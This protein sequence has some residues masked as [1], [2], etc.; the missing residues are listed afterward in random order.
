[1][2]PDDLLP[3]ANSD[4][5]PL[6]IRLVAHA[7][8]GAATLE[9]AELLCRLATHGYR[10]VARAAGLRLVVL[11]GSDGI[12]RLQKA[13]VTVDEHEDLNSLLTATRDAEL[14]LYGLA[15]LW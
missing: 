7:L 5:R 13:L 2:G 4:N 3:L 8:V 9:D 6:F 14:Q 10:M 12:G 11:A 1:M 15:Q